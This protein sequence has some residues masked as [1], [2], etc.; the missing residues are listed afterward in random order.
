LRSVFLESFR[1]RRRRRRW[2]LLVLAALFLSGGGVALAYFELVKAPGNVSH[3]SVEFTTPGQGPKPGSKPETFKWPFYGYTA[4]RT[5]YLDTKLDPPFYGTWQYKSGSLIEFQPILVDGVLYVVPNNGRAAAIDAATGD[6]KWRTK[7]GTLNA[8]SAAWSKGRLYIATL[9]GR[10]TCLDAKTGKRKWKRNLPSRSESSPVVIDDRVYFGSE[11]GTVYA[12]RAGDGGILWRYHAGG[13]VKA[14][15]AYRDGILYFGDYSGT[16][17]ALRAS[18]GSKLWST[19]TSG[20]AFQ[21]SGRFYSTP[22]VAYGRVYLGNTDGFVYSFGAHSG[23]LAWRHQTGAYVY[24]APAIG[25]GPGGRP[26]V[27]IGSYDSHFYAFD[28]RSGSV[29]WRYQAAGRI[30]GAPTVIGR[31]VYFSDLDTSG[32][33]GLDVRTGRRLFKRSTG[34]FNPMI[35][36]GKR[37]YMTGFSTIYA[38]VPR[39]RLSEREHVARRAGGRS[40]PEEAAARP[41]PR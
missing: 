37:M 1:P 19:D 36:D 27:F 40:R 33:S 25:P 24:S 7:V 4:A 35:S 18:N 21:Q 10:I 23:Q 11:D 16:V 5:R 39:S 38:M 30:S 8:S 32:T 15:L 20:R 29:L 34:K 22:A 28:A 17:T 13:A 2:P 14:A 9:S 26:T 12:M 31:V 3:P 41:E 6:V